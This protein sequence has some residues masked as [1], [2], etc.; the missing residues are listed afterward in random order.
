MCKQH[1][2]KCKISEVCATDQPRGISLHVT[3]PRNINR[4]VSE[5]TASC[6][7]ELW[8]TSKFHARS[9]IKYFIRPAIE[10]LNT[11]N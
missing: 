4:L 11:G 3:L 9:C 5:Y 1:A 10:T 2:T 8:Y 6:L 7:L